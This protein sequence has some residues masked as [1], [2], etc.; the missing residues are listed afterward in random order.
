M[1]KQYDNFFSH[2]ECDTILKELELYQT[3]F[4]HLTGDIDILGKCFFY[5]LTK[6]WND[7]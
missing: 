6:I 1:F 3:E 7:F 5:C 4:R 2:N